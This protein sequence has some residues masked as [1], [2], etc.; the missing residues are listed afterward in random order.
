MTLEQRFLSKVKK[1]AGC[2]AWAAT[3]HSGVGYGVIKVGR[4]CLF[5]HRVSFELFC[6]EIKKGL[7][8]LHECDNR[9]CVRPDHLFL[10]TRAQNAADRDAKGR[11][12]KGVDHYRAKLKTGDI[13]KIRK[14]KRTRTSLAKDY[15]VSRDAIGKIVRRETWA[16]I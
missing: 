16:H 13:K 1:S 10:G 8:V 15:G 6:G 9:L 14:S 7:C 12:S 11:C 3:Q 4:K 5:A 2:W